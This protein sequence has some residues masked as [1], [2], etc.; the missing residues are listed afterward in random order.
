M[1]TALP[2]VPGVP[3]AP[4]GKCWAGSLPLLLPAPCPPWGPVLSGSRLA[5]I[6]P[7]S[8]QSLIRTGAV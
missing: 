4:G 7:S 5:G 6:S 3:P 8:G 2:Q 1:R